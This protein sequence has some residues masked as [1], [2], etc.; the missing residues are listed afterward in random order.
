MVCAGQLCHVNKYKFFSQLFLFLLILM[1]HIDV[2]LTEQINITTY[3]RSQ[4]KWVYLKNIVLRNKH[5]E[6]VCVM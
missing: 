4:D 3:R 2:H 5:L 1:M 6:I